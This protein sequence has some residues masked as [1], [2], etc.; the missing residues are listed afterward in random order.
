MQDPSSPDGDRG[1]SFSSIMC[2]NTADSCLVIG[3]KQ[4]DYR[5]D[6]M[7]VRRKIE[8]DEATGRIGAH[9]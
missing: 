6:S 1:L 3:S 4:R 9:W 2:Y 8:Y 7:H 5:K